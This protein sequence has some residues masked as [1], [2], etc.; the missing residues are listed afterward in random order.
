MT[1]V[2]GAQP[3]G[4]NYD[5]SGSTCRIFAG[6]PRGWIIL[7]VQG[8]LTCHT[9]LGNSHKLNVGIFEWYENPDQQYFLNENPWETMSISVMTEG[10]DSKV[11]VEKASTRPICWEKWP[12]KDDCQGSQPPATQNVGIH[13]RYLLRIVYLEFQTK[14]GG[15]PL[16]AQCNA[17]FYRELASQ[18][19]NLLT[20]SPGGPENGIHHWKLCSIH[21]K[22]C[23]NYC[24]SRLMVLP[25]LQFAH[26]WD[27]ILV[28]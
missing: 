6:D 23:I 2:F 19:P 20:Y 25:L 18:V 3:A 26:T 4:C 10:C 11:L 24:K 7:C 12:L 21:C 27:A 9:R 13:Q 15:F 22:S 5:S 17:G 8:K 28:G 1:R 16:L 14:Y